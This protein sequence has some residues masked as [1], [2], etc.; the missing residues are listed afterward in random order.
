[1]KFSEILSLSTVLA[2]ASAAPVKRS[3]DVEITFIGAAGAQ[4]TQSFPTDGTATS[5]S[6]VL[7]ISHISSSTEGV[8]CTFTGVDSSSTTVDGVEYVD[9]GPPQT[10]V[11][12]SCWN[13]YTTQRRGTEDAWITFIG[14]ADA[15]FSQSFPLDG[16]PTAISNV[17]SISH[18]SSSANGYECTF[19]GIDGSS[20]T[21]AGAEE[22][23]V[24]PPQTQVSGTCYK[25]YAKTRR[26][27]DAWITFIGAAD[28]EFS[29]SF[30]TDGTPTSISNVLSISHISSSSSGVECT[31]TGVDGSS[32]TVDGVEEVDVGP[33]QTQVSGTCHELPAQRRR[34]SDVKVTFIGAA[35]AEFVQYFP[36]DSQVVSISNVLSISHIEVEASGVTCTFGGI[37]NSVTTVTGPSTVDVG[38]PQTQVSGYC[39]A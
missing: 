39:W 19:T 22:V 30:P 14:A 36:T 35:D 15:E 38:P 11:S 32:T 8:E 7:S 13:V 12:G 21:V 9:V 2:L 24:G 1:M 26:S 25:V 31:F 17:L 29:Q 4:F 16:T 5:I 34:S 3:N 20:T 18:I 6:N 23:D 27:A 28:A 33:P 37:D 10:Q